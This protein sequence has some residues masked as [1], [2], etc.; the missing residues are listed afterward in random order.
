MRGKKFLRKDERNGA[1]APRHL[2]DG[3]E[4]RLDCGADLVEGA[5]AG[6]DGHARE[7]DDVLDGRDLGTKLERLISYI[8]RSGETHNQVA[9][10]DLEDLGLGARAPGERLLEKGDEDVAEG[11]GDHGSVE[12]HLG[13]ARGE[14]AAVLGAVLGNHGR[15]DFL[16]TVKRTGGKH[17]GAPISLN[18]SISDALHY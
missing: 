3:H 11:R 10:D 18:I 15:E 8:S 9:D 14:V 13:H 1:G 5:R 6:D 2:H 12:R 16:Q 17:L 4:P 7:V